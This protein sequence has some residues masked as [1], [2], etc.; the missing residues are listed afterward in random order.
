MLDSILPGG[1]TLC[2]SKTLVDDIREKSG[3]IS[4]FLKSKNRSA[5]EI[6]QPV[7]AVY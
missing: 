6:A 3:A 1:L 4:N 5:I 2:S 7:S